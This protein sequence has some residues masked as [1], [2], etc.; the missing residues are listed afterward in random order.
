M[1]KRKFKKEVFRQYEEQGSVCIY[2]DGS[3]LF[4]DITRDHFIPK[5]SGATLKNNKVFACWTC[6]S[7]KEDDTI[8]E[9]HAR[10]LEEIR[11]I[12]TACVA[13]DWKISEDDLSRFKYLS[14]RFKTIGKIIDNGGKPKILFT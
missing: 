1:K 2:C 5:A 14:K 8:E 6:N 7:D 11:D 9:L 3:F 4:E 10:D 13:N 12:L